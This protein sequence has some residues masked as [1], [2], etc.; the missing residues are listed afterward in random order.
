MTLGFTGTK[1]GMTDVQLRRVLTLFHELPLTELHHGDCVGAD[2]EA[3]TLARTQGALIILHPPTDVTR[4]AF[5]RDAYEIREPS[6]YLTRNRHI[7]QEGIDGL[8]AAPREMSTPA[9]LRG[10]GTWTTIGYARQAER[11]IWIV[12]PDGTVER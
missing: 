3:H 1:H 6:T 11:K 9:S 2:A 8:I 7:V 10:H 4:R 5:C 12:L